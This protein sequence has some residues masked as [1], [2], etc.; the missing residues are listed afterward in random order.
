PRPRLVHP[1]KYNGSRAAFRG[2][3][4]QVRNIINVNPDMYPTQASRVAYIGSLFTKEALQWY[5][6]LVKHNSPLL[7]NYYA[8]LNEF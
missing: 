3:L 4:S 6:P 2:F 7:R 5:A 8:F 1:E